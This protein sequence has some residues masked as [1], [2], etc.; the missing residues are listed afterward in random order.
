MNKSLA[1][2]QKHV[3]QVNEEKGWYEAERTFGDEIALIHTELSEAFEAFRSHG[4]E[5]M[6]AKLCKKCDDFGRH[7]PDHICKPEGVGSEL[8]DVLIRLLD[9]CERHNVD[10]EDELSRK[11]EFNKTRPWRHGGKRV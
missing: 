4:F 1:E 9:T 3:K 5:D 6:T 10:V 8:A 7:A 11:I 2:W